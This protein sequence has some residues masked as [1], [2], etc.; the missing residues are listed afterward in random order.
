MTVH[1]HSSAGAGG[2]FDVQGGNPILLESVLNDPTLRKTT[3]VLVQGGW[4][5][6]RQTTA[7]LMKPNAY[8]DTSMQQML[9][10]PATL[11]MNIREFLELVPEKV[12]FGTDCYPFSPEL[13]WEEAAWMGVRN[14]RRALGMALT[15]MVRD[16]SITRER[17]IELARMVMRENA[18]KLYGL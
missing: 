6:I 3:F 18:R 10:S 2:Y 11:A 15:G 16:G 14:A 1:I 13:G 4:P 12:M 5:F 17:A 9:L 8:L 7:L